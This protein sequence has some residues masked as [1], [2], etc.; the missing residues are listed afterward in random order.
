MACRRRSRR[1]L[2]RHAG[3]SGPASAASG[4]SLQGDSM[5]TLHIAL[6]VRELLVDGARQMAMVLLAS[7]HVIAW[8]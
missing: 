2:S 8:C 5:N 7:Q 4:A 6:T 1:V 3:P